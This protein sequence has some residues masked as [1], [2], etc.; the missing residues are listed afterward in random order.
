M[1][2]SEWD[3]QTYVLVGNVY[4]ISGA[5]S[6]GQHFKYKSDESEAPKTEYGHRTES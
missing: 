2:N 3:D 5:I 4:P 1:T 6:R